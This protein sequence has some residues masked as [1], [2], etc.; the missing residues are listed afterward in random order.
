MQEPK[1]KLPPRCAFLEQYLEG[2]EMKDKAQRR[3]T[4]MKWYSD[5]TKEVSSTAEIIF[6]EL[7]M[8]RKTIPLAKVGGIAGGDKYI[9]NGILYKLYKKGEVLPEHFMAAKSAATELRAANVLFRLTYN[10]SLP[11]VVPP[12]MLFDRL[13]QRLVAMPYL[14]LAE[15]GGLIY[16]SNN[17]GKNVHTS[18][19]AFNTVVQYMAEQLNLAGHQVGSAFLHLACDVEGHLGSD[20]RFYLLDLGRVFPP[21][22]PEEV[23]FLDN[24]T[25]RSIFFRFLRPEFLLGSVSSNRPAVSCDALSWFGEHNR[26]RHDGNCRE[27]TRDLLDQVLPQLAH[28][29]KQ[30]HQGDT[31]DIESAVKPYLE[32]NHRLEEQMKPFVAE[33]QEKSREEAFD[34][35]D[36]VNKLHSEAFEMYG[37]VSFQGPSTNLIRKDPSL[38]RKWNS[39][40]STVDLAARMHTVG[41]PVRL[42]GYLHSLLSDVPQ[43]QMAC[44]KVILERSIKAVFRQRA[45]AHRM[46]N[47]DLAEV[48]ALVESSPG[49]PFWKD[50]ESV[51]KTRFGLKDAS[52]AV[53]SQT[54]RR[55]SSDIVSYVN[56]RLGKD[57][58][59][60][61]CMSFLEILR[62]E[63]LL[64]TAV[65]L[66]LPQIS[67]RVNE[68]VDLCSALQRTAAGDEHALKLQRQ[69]HTCQD[70]LLNGTDGPGQVRRVRAFETYVSELG[71]ESSMQQEEEEEEPGHQVCAAIM[72]LFGRADVTLLLHQTAQYGSGDKAATEVLLQAG[73]DPNAIESGYSVLMWAAQN[74]HEA[75]AE[76]LL[77]AGADPNAKRNDDSTTALMLAARAGHESVAEV[78]LQAGAD[79][80]AKRDNGVTPLM[81]AAQNGYET[82]VRLLLQHGADPNAKRWD[83]NT[84]LMFA[85][86]YGQV[87]AAQVLLQAGADLNAR[88]RY[89]WPARFFATWTGHTEVEQVLIEAG[90]DPCCFVAVG[91]R[92]CLCSCLSC[93]WL[94]GK[95]K[96][97][98]NGLWSKCSWKKRPS[99]TN[100]KSG[101]YL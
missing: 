4:L 93:A 35:E 94:C 12:V 75:T 89:F 66:S 73:A 79:P 34:G 74:G 77:Q 48:E 39:F 32:H 84:A 1:K 24:S 7:Y 71:T 99:A 46:Q 76:V 3:E 54:A 13:D 19:K 83:G 101:V 95:V 49:S 70:L 20:G 78:L 88:N 87:A 51:V 92:C 36:F 9:K 17:A 60:I 33:W 30:E 63:S 80:N 11:V 59:F 68:V 100:R 37:R 21:E 16:G 97:A 61:K 5:F 44:L 64:A 31:F 8:D 41:A 43:L 53:L 23:P 47:L 38:Q 45:N 26:K 69:A 27:A 28:E 56:L 82:L 98:I 91:D 15:D 18:N 81:W 72:K 2:L 14:P 42:L 85:A 57:K 62:A 6:Q 52:V 67:A 58:P 25:K 10:Y 96:N 29:L 50:V 90:A 40:A 55:N 86:Y 65:G 22:H